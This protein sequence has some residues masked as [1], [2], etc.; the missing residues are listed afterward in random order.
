MSWDVLDQ[1]DP[2]G[3]DAW[4]LFIEDPCEKNLGD[5]TTFLR[6]DF[7]TFCALIVKIR[8][9]GGGYVVPFLFNQVQR[10]IWREICKMLDEGRPLWFVMLKFRQAGMST[11]WCSWLFWQ[12]WRQRDIQTMI[13]AHQLPT[14]ETM[15]ETMKVIYDE[16]P[17]IFRPDLREGNHGASIPRGEVYFADRRCWGLIHLAKNVDPRGQQVT[18]VLETEHAMYPNP[19]ELNA[20]LLPALPTFGS[21][22]RLRSSFI[23][24]STPKGQNAFHDLY[25]NAK[26]GITHT[27]HAMFFPWF[28]FDEQYSAEAPDTFRM[29]NEEKKEMTRLS[30]MRMEDYTIE[31]GGGVPVTR[32]QMYWRRETILTDFD[33][34]DDQ[35]LQE[36]PSDD[37]SCWLLGSKSVFKEY[38]PYLM[39]SVANAR[40]RAVAAWGACDIKTTGPVRLQL[41]PELDQR[42]TH[43]TPVVGVTFKQNAHGSWMVWE[44]PVPGHKY[45]IGGDPALGLNEG[46]Y[47]VIC[48][49]DVTKGRQVA[50]FCEH[51]GPEKF[52]TE[53]A[54]A[55]W[56]YN[57]ALLVPEI[58]SI[59]Y[60]VLKRLIAN[61]SYPNLFRWP[62]WD[63]VNRFTHKRGWETNSRTK[64]LAVST[65]T[66]YLDTELVEIASK[67]LLSEMS[68]FEAKDEGDYW[69]FEAQKG[70]HDDRVMA[71][72]LALAGVEQTPILN[73]EMNRSGSKMPSTSDLHLAM[74]AADMQAPPLPKQL[75]EIIA[76]QQSAIHWNCFGDA[77]A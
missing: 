68:T 52:A 13:V 5:I 54:A 43:W 36:Y 62:K 37:V 17:E 21:E 38:T 10:R 29:T 24:E 69:S 77:V 40:D 15:I 58:N 59:G 42:Q 56:W 60:V 35:F 55:G 31:D 19:Q 45:S 41:I 53:L 61:L 47:S 39:D 20:A 8:P 18:H 1:C 57:Q 3:L 9:K 30:R 72:G 75:Q 65:M 67:E 46:D 26:K 6:E 50:E 76:V 22:A 70:R 73:L 49:I 44:P 23:I 11:F 25:V 32:N 27:Y 51:M 48:V 7:P 12:M 63:E 74:S 28:L 34:D 2:A 71:F 66:T 64:Q 14:A 4:N 16:M 33:G